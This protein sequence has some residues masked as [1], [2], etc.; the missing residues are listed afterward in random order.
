MG[1]Q[2]Q[3]I[4][5]RTRQRPIPLIAQTQTKYTKSWSDDRVQQV[6]EN[7]WQE[8]YVGAE[9]NWEAKERE[10]RQEIGDHARQIKAFGQ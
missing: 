9:K 1:N 4:A 7:P 2:G 10:A 8:A 6:E 3:K 5:L